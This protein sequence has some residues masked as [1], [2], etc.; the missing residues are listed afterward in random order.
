MS[1]NTTKNVSD[2]K[3]KKEEKVA[4]KQVVEIDEDFFIERDAK[5]VPKEIKESY[6]N[7]HFHWARM[8]QDGISKV[9]SKG[10]QL[11]RIPES[12]R[13]VVSVQLFKP[14][15]GFNTAFGEDVL[16]YRDLILVMCP[17]TLYFKR[18]NKIELDKRGQG[19]ARAKGQ[20]HLSNIRDAFGNVKSVDV[21]VKHGY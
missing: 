21:S 18:K 15:S 3:E 9:F 7:M 8:D 1:D 4:K 20:K 5:E 14:H 2:V 16:V 11:V 10:Y 6:P 19:L 12:C 13:N 17:E